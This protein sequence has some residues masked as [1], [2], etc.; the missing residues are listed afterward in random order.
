MDDDGKNEGKVGRVRVLFAPGFPDGDFVAQK[1]QGLKGVGLGE[2]FEED[3]E[4]GFV[5]GR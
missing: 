4:Q 2:V 1:A 5:A 3:V